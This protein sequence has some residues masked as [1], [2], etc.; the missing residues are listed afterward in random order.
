MEHIGMDV[1]KQETQVC[2]EDTTGTVVLEQRIRTTPERFTA[3]L[4]GRP[5]ARILLEAAT[6]SEWVAQ[7]LETLGH[8]VIVA[9][10]NY[11]AMYATRSRR[12]KTD[13]RDARTL[14]DA[15]RLGAYHPAHR[16]SAAQRAVRAKLA[17]REALVQTRTRYLSVIRALLRRE[18]IRVPS[19]SAA[20][21][22]RRLRQVAVAP[23]QAAVVAPLVELLAPLNAAIAAADARVARRLAADPVARRLATTPGVGP[24][25]AVAFV[26]TLDDVTRFARP[27]QVAA[28]LGLVPRE[29]SSG[30][31]QRRGA[32]TKAG[33]KRLRW[34]LVQAAWG[35]WRDR[36]AA[37]QPLRSWAVALAA[38]RGKGVAGVA[39]ARRLAG[40]LFAL[41][42]DGTTFDP[43]RVGRRPHVSAAA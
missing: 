28:Y 34:L 38:R 27:G 33:N 1:H 12:V 32:V 6:E 19:G 26:A 5:R 16:T 15:C 21:F 43:A 36:H 22:P 40:I 39:L 11:A 3:L 35:V 8:E 18:G 29:R 13:R 10:P 9:D 24:V 31:R 25:T 2:I 23:T 30:E 42:R 41:W 17:V 20:A 14:A 4:C 7:H 37:S